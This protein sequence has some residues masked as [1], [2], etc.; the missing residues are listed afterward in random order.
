MEKQRHA[1]Q[2]ALVKQLDQSSCAET[3]CLIDANC[4]NVNMKKTEDILKRSESVGHVTNITPNYAMDS[5]VA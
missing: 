4:R 2:A 1:R 5:K 3:K